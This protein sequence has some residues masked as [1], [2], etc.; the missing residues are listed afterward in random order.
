MIHEL[1]ELVRYCNV[2]PGY[3]MDHDLSPTGWSPQGIKP[4]GDFLNR[5]GH[6]MDD[7]PHK[8][9]CLRYDTRRWLGA[10]HQ[11]GA[12]LVRLDGATNPSEFGACGGRLIARQKH[13]V[14][15]QESDRH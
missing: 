11:D 6:L 13:G 5:C 4:I 2:K 8:F 9:E 12:V 10:A 14:S 3:V 1:Y 15:D 7:D